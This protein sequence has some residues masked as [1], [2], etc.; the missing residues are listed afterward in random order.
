MTRIEAPAAIAAAGVMTRFW[1]PTRASAGRIP[2]TTKKPSAQ[3]ARAAATSCPEQTMP[4]SPASRAN[5]ASRS[6]CAAGSPPTPIAARSSASRLVSTVTPTTLVP[7]GAAALAAAIIAAPPAAWTVITAGVIGASAATAL[8]T[9]FG[10]SWSFKSRNS[11]S[12]N[13][14][15]RSA[16][17]RPL[18]WKNSSPSLIPPARP[19]QA[20]AIASARPISGVS[21]ATK[22]GEFTAWL[23]TAAPR[24]RR[25]AAAQASA[26]QARAARQSTGAVSAP[27]ACRA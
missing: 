20:R 12:P 22:T 16:P 17:S 15:S 8:A 10:I 24:R 1:S 27:T 25:M 26:C 6:T 9:V 7:A 3:A 5:A 14:A 11:G 18:R 4:S 13:S 21:I 19:A 23:K 2:G